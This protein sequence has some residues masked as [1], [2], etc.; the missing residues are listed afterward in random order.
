VKY[1]YQYRRPALV[2]DV[3]AMW[4]SNVLL[5][6]RAHDPFAGHFAL[7]GGY[8]DFG[9]S[10]EQAA[11]REFEEECGITVA[12]D[13]LH[14]LPARTNPTRDP[15]G[16]VVD[17]PF[18]VNLTREEFGD[19]RAGDDAASV[20]AVNLLWDPLPPLAFDH[21]DLLKDALIVRFR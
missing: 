5:I 10:A 14:P 8:V 17:I 19:A 4:Q 11:V 18:R 13:R 1:A 9:E 21:F 6:E 2:V 7:P 20:R 3:V 12:A 15:R 16:W